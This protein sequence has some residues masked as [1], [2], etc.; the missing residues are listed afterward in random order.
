MIRCMSFMALTLALAAPWGLAAE[1]G[2]PIKKKTAAIDPAK[3]DA[4]AGGVSRPIT[5]KTEPLVKPPDP[6][7]IVQ[8][9]DVDRFWMHSEYFGAWT[10]EAARPGFTLLTHGAGPVVFDQSIASIFDPHTKLY[11][12]AKEHYERQ[13]GFRA[14]FGAWIDDNKRFGAEISGFWAEQA[15]HEYKRT[16]LS[17]GG[18]TVD[19]AIGMP[20]VDRRKQQAAFVFFVDNVG[21]SATFTINS[22]QHWYGGEAMGVMN[23][24]RKPRLTI[25]AKFGF[26]Y[27]SLTEDLTIDYQRF[28]I[29][30]L[31]G[32]PLGN[33][34]GN[35]IGFFFD[36]ALGGSTYVVGSNI[37]IQDKV[38]ARNQFYGLNIA[39]NLKY[40]WKRLRL[41]FTPKIAV[42]PTWQHISVDGTSTRV[43]PTGRAVTLLGGFRALPSNMGTEDWWR[44]AAVGEVNIKAGVEIT[45]NINF[46]AGYN[47]M[48]ISNVVRA[49]T[50]FDN[51]LDERLLNY[52]ASAHTFPT[53]D[54]NF[55][56]P[57]F[58]DKTDDYHIH[59]VS[60]G[61]NFTW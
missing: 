37:L 59:A 20:F 41:D 22:K 56:G 5:K 47:L 50:Q 39:A 19:F 23:L 31:A 45:K 52:G 11:N 61:F 33:V 54:D 58:R 2:S 18:A 30:A 15:E 10:K 13:D 25:D 42:G 21:E 26:R 51:Q 60:L 16:F 53:D 36:P 12:R 6:T 27:F 38:E 46:M 24:Y 34:N 55:R 49:G 7:K 8:P 35:D 57:F 14:G 40:K 44:L 1:G 4:N 28:N 3:A 29:Q 43:E 17:N 32:S 48:Y 9:Q